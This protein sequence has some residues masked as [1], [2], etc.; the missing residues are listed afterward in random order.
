M[1]L[2]R[3]AVQSEITESGS[4]SSSGSGDIL[5]PTDIESTV[6]P[7]YDSTC[8]ISLTFSKLNKQQYHDN[9]LQDCVSSLLV[10]VLGLD[11]SPLIILMESDNVS[12]SN[13]LAYFAVESTCGTTLQSYAQVLGSTNNTGWTNLSEIYVSRKYCV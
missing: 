1:V 9:N 2:P 11:S 12:V 13:L 10:T 8:F 5:L 3:A 4:G 7:D 6:I